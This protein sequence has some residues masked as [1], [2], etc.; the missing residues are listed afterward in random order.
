MRTKENIKI[1]S[2]MGI[3]PILLLQ[4]LIISSCASPK[5]KNQILEPIPAF[6]VRRQPV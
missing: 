2:L 4:M 3:F 6:F 5:N 1:Y